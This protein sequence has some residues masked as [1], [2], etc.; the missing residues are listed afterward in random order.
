MS[1]N[2]QVTSFPMFKEKARHVRKSA[3]ESVIKTGK[4]HLGGA[5]SCV[6]ILV[7]LYYSGFLRIN[8]EDAENPD[9]DYF[10]MGKGHACISL[11]PILFDRGFISKSEFESY[12]QDGGKLGGQLDRGI[13]GVEYN[14]GSL[15]HVLGTSAGIAMSLL[16]CKRENRAIALVGDAELEEGAMW[17]A[18]YFAAKHRLSNLVCVIDR[19]KLSVTRDIDNHEIFQSFSD[20]ISLMGWHCFEINGHS[21]DEL[22]SVL[23]EIERADKPT[24]VVAHTIKGKGVSFMENEIKWHHSVPNAEEVLLAKVE[25]GFDR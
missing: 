8:P 10:L 5:F 11:Y 2:K 15:G 6:E 25:L 19:N 3:L 9:R 20:K 22:I 23:K 4:G 1:A 12:G 7:S 18:I 24:M 16:Q 17:E 21:F 14:T 13:P